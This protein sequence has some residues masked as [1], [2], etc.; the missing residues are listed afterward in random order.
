MPN[1][2]VSHKSKIEIEIQIVIE[3]VKNPIRSSKILSSHTIRI[4]IMIFGLDVRSQCSIPSKTLTRTWQTLELLTGTN[5]T[6]ST[7]LLLV[8]IPGYILE[9]HRP[10]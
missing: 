5:F 4:S 7:V 8:R 2:T 6:E 9:L 3:S 10:I 1:R